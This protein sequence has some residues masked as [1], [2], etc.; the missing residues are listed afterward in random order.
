[1]IDAWLR[2]DSPF[3]SLL[4]HLSLM[5]D[6]VDLD[7]DLD[8]L[9]YGDFD[10]I[11]PDDLDIDNLERELGL[12]SDNPKEEAANDKTTSNT[13]EPSLKEHSKDTSKDANAEATLSETP[14]T[15]KTPTSPKKTAPLTSNSP[16]KTEDVT[17][18]NQSKPSSSP[19]RQQQGTNG[20]QQQYNP[21]MNRSKHPMSSQHHHPFN[22]GMMNIK[23][24]LQSLS[25]SLISLPFLPFLYS[26]S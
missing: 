4:Y 8:N 18:N 21:R 22:P 15:A 2:F 14:S 10:D 25:F 5:S 17:S 23:Y 11:N 9:D 20:H 16:S 1:M 3:S 13:S 12:V 26:S 24:V 6:T 19:A 7:I